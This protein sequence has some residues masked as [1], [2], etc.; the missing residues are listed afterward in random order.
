MTLVANDPA[1]NVNFVPRDAIAAKSVSQDKTP[2][3]VPVKA[4]P[5]SSSPLFVTAKFDPICNLYPGDVVPIPTFP[6]VAASTVAPV[7]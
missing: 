5:Q 7:T 2:L 3:D 6:D 1:E 4:F